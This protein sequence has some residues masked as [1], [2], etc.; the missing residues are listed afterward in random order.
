MIERLDMA[1][2]P[3]TKVGVVSF[4]T[5]ARTHC[6]L[7]NQ[8][9]RAVGCVNQ[10]GAGGGTRIDRGIEEGMK[11]LRRGRNKEADR[12]SI[13]EVM[14]VLSDG[15]NNAGCPPVLQAAGSAK[16]QGVLVIT[17]CVGNDCDT[18]CMRR[19]ATS[20][21]YFFEA[22]NASAL[23]QV[24]DR[25][26]EDII[27]IFLRKLTVVDILPSNMHYILD[28]G[29]SAP[30]WDEN[31]RELEWQTVQV[32]KQGVT[33]TARVEPKEVGFW[34]TNVEAKGTFLDN[35][36]RSGEFTFEVP[37]VTVLNPNVQGTPS[38]PPPPPTYTPTPPP[39]PTPRPRP[40]YLP[41][42]LKQKCQIQEHHA[43]IVLV[44]DMSTSMTWPT[45]NGRQKVEAV[46]EASKSFA[47]TIDMTPNELD[48]YSQVGVVG[49]NHDAWVEVGLTNNLG[50]VY[51]AI[52]RLPDG[53]RQHTRLDLAV[54]RGGETALGPGHKA[55]NTPVVILLTDGR[56]Q[57]RC[58]TTKTAPW[59]PRSCARRKPPSSSAW[60]STP[61]GWVC[62]TPST[63]S[64]GSTPTC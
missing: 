26:R 31:L 36:N 63:Q 60:S 56:A 1:E 34:P 37:Y 17:V 44:L 23:G 9:N 24:F 47:A 32:P 7:T 49:F 10:V 25:I 53:M 5:T 2:N 12:E 4:N 55:D 38:A 58:R 14:I 28:A 52:G 21:R 51:S 54:E 29:D 40:I 27:N 61:S 41:V 18:S 57:P 43:D 15:G 59:K 6:Q 3:A 42:N 46:E 13:R 20:P 45:Q 19:A 22:R 39:T 16:S 11:V 35:K 8:Q 48:Q 62:P 33:Y 64:S 50:D 30:K